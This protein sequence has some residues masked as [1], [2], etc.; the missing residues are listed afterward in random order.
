MAVVRWKLNEFLQGKGLS[1]YRL[2]TE[3][4]GQI[5]RTGLYKITRGETSGVD[6]A[7][8]ADILEALEKLTG[9]PVALQDVLSYER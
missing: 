5:S 9:E 6:F 8:L 2:H 4:A 1:V 3:L 7:S